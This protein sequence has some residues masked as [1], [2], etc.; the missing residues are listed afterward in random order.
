MSGVIVHDGELTLTAAYTLEYIVLLHGAADAREHIANL[1]ETTTD[2]NFRK[3][4]MDMNQIFVIVP[5]DY[6]EICGRTYNL[7]KEIGQG[8]Q[9]ELVK[10]EYPPDELSILDEAFIQGLFDM[11]TK[12]KDAKQDYIGTARLF[13]PKSPK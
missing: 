10:I 7:I 12:R 4:L 2:E 13:Y 6:E 8:V 9:E 1:L 5:T 11:A 3:L